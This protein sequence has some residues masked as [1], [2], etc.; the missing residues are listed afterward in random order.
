MIK[1]DEFLNNREQYDELKGFSE[2]EINFLPT[3][4]FE[5]GTNV[6]ARGKKKRVPSWCDR[7]LLHQEDDEEFVRQISYDSKEILWGDHKPVI[8]HF[9]I[10]KQSALEELVEIIPKKKGGMR[11]KKVISS[12]EPHYNSQRKGLFAS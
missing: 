2:L 8:S 5:D 11:N 4:K 7:I 3:Y 6:Y 1:K 10:C 12:I 9:S